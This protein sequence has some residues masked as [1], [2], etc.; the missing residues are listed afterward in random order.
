MTGALTGGEI[1][2][3]GQYLDAYQRVLGAR[4]RLGLYGQGGAWASHMLQSVCDA[5]VWYAALPFWAT[6][7]QPT[8]RAAIIQRT[9]QPVVCG[10]TTDANETTVPAFGAWTPL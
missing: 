8:C 4:W 6:N 2:A 7:A 10:Y 3:L 1:D 9:G 5:A